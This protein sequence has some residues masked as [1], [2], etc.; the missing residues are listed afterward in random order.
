[1]NWMAARPAELASLQ[2]KGR[3]AAGSAADLCVFAPNDTFVVDPERLHHKNP[4]TPYAGHSLTG[5][6]RSTWLRG[7]RIGIDDE[8]RGRLLTRG[9][10]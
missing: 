2:H 10:S 6:V 9:A 1:M 4:T 5:V 3:I 7:E 8:P